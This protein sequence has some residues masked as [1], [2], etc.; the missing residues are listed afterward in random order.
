MKEE[1]GYWF[2]LGLIYLVSP[3]LGVATTA[4]TISELLGTPGPSWVTLLYL[5]CGVG[6]SYSLVARLYL[7]EVESRVKC[8]AARERERESEIYLKP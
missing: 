2:A 7:I 6:A 5:L 4:F 3:L 8:K 1:I